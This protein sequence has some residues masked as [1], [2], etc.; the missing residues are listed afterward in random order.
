MKHLWGIFL[1]CLCFSV[2]SQSYKPF[3]EYGNYIFGAH[4]GQDSL[5]LTLS[6]DSIYDDGIDSVFVFNRVVHKKILVDE[7]YFYNQDNVF[8]KEY[9]KKNNGDLIFICSNGDSMLLK[10]SVGVGSSWI[11]SGSVNATLSSRSLE[12]TIGGMDSVLTYQLSNGQT[13]RLSQ[14][15]GLLQSETWVLRDHAAGPDNLAYHLVGSQGLGIGRNIAQFEDFFTFPNGA[16]FQSWWPG[17]LGY[18]VGRR[19][20]WH[21]QNRLSIGNPLDFHYLRLRE[22]VDDDWS[23]QYHTPP[24]LDTLTFLHTSYGYLNLL[25][26]QGDS[27]KILQGI[28]VDPATQR[29][30]QHYEVRPFFWDSNLQAYF[31]PPTPLRNFKEWWYMEEVGLV[32]QLYPYPNVPRTMYLTCYNIGKGQEQWSSSYPCVDMTNYTSAPDPLL[33]EASEIYPN[34]ASTECWVKIP[35][36][37]P[38]KIKF[39]VYSSNGS[40]IKEIPFSE[41]NTHFQ[42]DLREWPSG[43][44]LVEIQDEIGRRCVK[45]V[46]KD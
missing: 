17:Y 30:I 36:N 13:I 22:M 19:E 41:D 16:Y 11:F 5:L 10:T 4:N 25:S 45:K 24:Y 42:I 6:I 2:Q 39:K 1:L 37:Y 40:L 18:S 23:T 9:R 38:S 32:Q 26:G 35:Q 28:T 20:D 14:H 8:G 34:P 29:W 27:S 21:I 44:Y 15:F 33:L 46:L 12:N 43:I 3:P 7:V 31:Q